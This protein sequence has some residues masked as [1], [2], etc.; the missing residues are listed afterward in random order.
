MI[1]EVNPEKV[2]E[3]FPKEGFGELKC[4]EIPVINFGTIWKYMIESID[5]KKQLSTAKPLVKGYNFYKSG[6]VLS[7]FVCSQERRCFIKSKVLPSM[8]KK[9]VDS[10]YIVH[11]SN[12]HVKESYCGCPAGVDGRC[13]HI[14]ATLFALEEYT[15][16]QLKKYQ[17]KTSRTLE[18]CTWNI[19]RKR[20]GDVA[21]IK[22]LNFQ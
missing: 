9:C 10:C 20:K 5:A 7:V 2:M 17:Q 11:L 19:P 15:R 4:Q 13:N 14:A 3:K 1:D 6:H 21:P 18:P 12:G 22:A 8:K 16:Q